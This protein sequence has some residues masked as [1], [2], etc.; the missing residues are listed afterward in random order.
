LKIGILANITKTNTQDVALR[1]VHDLEARGHGCIVEAELAGRIGAAEGLPMAE[2]CAEAELILSLGGDGSVLRAVNAAAHLETP[3]LGINMGRVGFL[4]EVPPTEIAGLLD[5]IDSGAFTLD[6][7]S[8]LQA[9]VQPGGKDP[10]GFRYASFNDVSIT[11]DKY[12]CIVRLDI[13][14]QDEFAGTVVGDGVLVSTPTGS[15]AYALSCGGPLVHPSL[16]ALLVT[17]I[18]GHVAGMRPMVVPGGSVIRIC[19]HDA[20]RELDLLVDG[21]FGARISANDEAIVRRAPFQA[22]LAHIKPYRYFDIVRSK[23]YGENGGPRDQKGTG[24]KE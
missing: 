24:C 23:I 4:S 19:P 1:L 3:V 7:R 15:T 10:A 2:I 20:H 18:S 6:R 14:V 9:A 11:R 17:P 12:A 22:V 8:M 13:F 21:K 16:D 5:A